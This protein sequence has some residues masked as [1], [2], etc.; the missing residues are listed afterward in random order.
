MSVNI[1]NLNGVTKE[2]LSD[3]L[4]LDEKK[5]SK[6]VLDLVIKRVEKNCV[7]KASFEKYV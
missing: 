6:K 2:Y 1:L 7:S 3:T 5:T 4:Y